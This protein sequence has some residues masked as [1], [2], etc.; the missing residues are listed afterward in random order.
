VNPPNVLLVVLDS[1]RARNTSLHGHVNETTPRLD[2]FAET[3]TR[4]TQARASG[5]HSISSHASL[6]TGYQVPEHG[7]YRQRGERIKPGHTIWEQLRDEY[8]YDTGLFTSNVIVSQTSNIG[9]GFEHVDGPRTSG[10]LFEDAIGPD[11]VSD[12]DRWQYLRELFDAGKPFRGFVNGLYHLLS[13]PD[14]R[15]Q[16]YVDSLLDWTADVDGPWAACVNLME[17]HYP[18]QPDEE[19]DLFGDATLRSVYDDLPAGP[20]AETYLGDESWW[21][22]KATESMYDGA[23]RQADAAVGDLLDALDQRGVLD[24][25]LVVATSDHGEG[26]GEQ[27]KVEPDVRLVDHSWG[28]G[29]ELVH[30]PLVVK[31]PGQAASHRVDE[32]V[33]LAAFPALVRDVVAG[34]VE[35]GR[36]FVSED[37][38]VVYNN[39]V[40]AD[41]NPIPDNHPYANKCLG[42]W[43]AMYE[44]TD[45]GALKYI[46]RGDSSAK[47]LVADAQ[48]VATVGAGD[49]D[50]VD[51]TINDLTER[52]VRVSETNDNLDSSTRD[53]LRE[54]GYVE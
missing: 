23:I 13:P 14:E 6:F 19:Y 20:Q 9:R 28:I 32:V 17:A 10:K 12:I 48:N 1:V 31:Q 30:V 40:H 27:S 22:L 36:G 50:L 52:D 18:Y 34:D 5:T 35:I 43:K 37:P 29:E 4:Y 15:G 47:V 2:E 46:A 53:R 44:S 25:T 26:F 42:P 16:V 41:E 45:D 33:S 39:R 54:L 24:Q 38:V 3:A 51:R 21:K 11:D 8:S 49:V 7:L